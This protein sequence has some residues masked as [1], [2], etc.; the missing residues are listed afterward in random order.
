MRYV[1]CIFLIVSLVVFSCKPEP[2]YEKN[3][4]KVVKTKVALLDTV[5]TNDTTSMIYTFSLFD[6]HPNNKQI[7]WLVKNYYLKLIEHD[8]STKALSSHSKIQRAHRFQTEKL[9]I[10]LMIFF[11]ATKEDALSIWVDNDFSDY[12]DNNY[13]IIGSVLYV[14]DGEDEKSVNNLLSWFATEGQM[15]YKMENNT[16]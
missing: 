4:E 13:G 11:C 1:S 8:I 6:E 3:D 12:Y 7:S 15:K 10:S 16:D 5:F 2:T 9:D 14:V